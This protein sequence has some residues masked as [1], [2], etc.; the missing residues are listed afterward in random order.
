M[1][2]LGLPTSSNGN[3]AIPNGGHDKL[4]RISHDLTGRCG[5]R[6]WAITEALEIAGLSNWSDGCWRD[7]R[8]CSDYSNLIRSPMSPH[9]TSGRS[10]T[11]I[12]SPIGKRRPRKVPGGRGSESEPILRSCPSNLLTVVSTFF[13]VTSEGAA[14]TSD[15]GA[16]LRSVEQTARYKRND[17]SC[18]DPFLRGCSILPQGNPAS[19]RLQTE[20]RERS[21]VSNFLSVSSPDQRMPMRRSSR[22][23]GSERSAV[24]MRYPPASPLRAWPSVLSPS[25]R[26]TLI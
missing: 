13:R 26:L 7:H 20:T 12:T 3:Q 1:A 24:R 16:P 21:H 19:N 9:A 22:W 23:S 4:H 15:A 14:V 11:I 2:S 10:S 25:A 8:K 18:S 5:S 17:L 6:L